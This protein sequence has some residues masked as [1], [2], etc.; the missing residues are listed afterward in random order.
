VSN[1][2]SYHKAA[3]AGQKPQIYTDLPQPGY[4]RARLKKDGPMLP[5]AIYEANMDSQG[6]PLM[7]CIVGYYDNDNDG[8]WRERDPCDVWTWCAD[9]P[10]RYEDWIAVCKTHRWS[11]ERDPSIELLEYAREITETSEDCGEL[12]SLWRKLEESRKIENAIHLD[13]KRMVDIKHKAALEAIKER[14]KEL[15]RVEREAA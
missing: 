15:K 9:K 6:N 4:Y 10:I 2:F 3:L 14:M 1:D 5:I 12:E 13:A 11:R 7:T 8:L